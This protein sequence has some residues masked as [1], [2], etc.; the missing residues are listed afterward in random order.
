MIIV[1]CK[2]QKAKIEQALVKSVYADVLKEKATSGLIATTSMPAAT[3]TARNYPIGAADRATL[4]TWIGK[5]RS[6]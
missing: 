1:Q 3:R 5:L 2:R 4:K 6:T